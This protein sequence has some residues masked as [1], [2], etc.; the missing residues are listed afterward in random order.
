M[1]PLRVADADRL[2]LAVTELLGDAVPVPELLPA[3]GKAKYRGRERRRRREGN[4]NV[5]KIGAVEKNNA[6]FLGAAAGWGPALARSWGRS[7]INEPRHC[8][9]RLF[10]SR[11][12]APDGDAVSLELPVPVSV[13]VGVADRLPEAELVPAEKDREQQPGQA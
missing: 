5:M 8:S 12:D 6:Q 2:P 10:R 3:K 7:P 1:V 13:G 4:V 11:V 9:P